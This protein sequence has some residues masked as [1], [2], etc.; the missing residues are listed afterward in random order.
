MSVGE[1]GLLEYLPDALIPFAGSRHTQRTSISLDRSATLFWWETLA[2]GRLAMGERFAYERLRIASSVDVCGRPILR[3]DFL[4]EP[5]LRPLAVSARVGGFTHVASF[6]AIQEG[7]SSAFWREVETTVGAGLPEGHWGVS[8]L[9]GGGVIVRGLSESGRDLPRALVKVW[10]L[11][12][13]MITGLE[14][15]PPRKVH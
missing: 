11:A 12:K 9:G 13:L 14:A 5:A 7:R 10:S 3:E 15:A 2:P 8:T 1:G 6:Y 4:L